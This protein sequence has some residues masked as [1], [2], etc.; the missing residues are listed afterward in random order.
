MRAHESDANLQKG[1][2]SP[3]KVTTYAAEEKNAGPNCDDSHIP[4]PSIRAG[5]KPCGGSERLE[6]DLV[7][8]CIDRIQWRE[9]R[10][11]FWLAIREE[12]SV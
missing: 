10:N 6:Q 9:K 12:D 3:R 8:P 1:Y 7:A 5:K 2:A 4:L 11:S